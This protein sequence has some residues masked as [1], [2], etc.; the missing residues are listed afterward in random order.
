M[1][2][3][4]GAG[5]ELVD[6]WR[7]CVGPTT[8]F[9]FLHP[10]FTGSSILSRMTAPELTMMAHSIPRLTLGSGSG[11]GPRSVLTQEADAD[12]FYVAS[13]SDTTLDHFR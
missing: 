12:G 1:G 5:G 10:H 8:P 6:R 11:S 3:L 4:W 7:P 13:L 9:P 2:S